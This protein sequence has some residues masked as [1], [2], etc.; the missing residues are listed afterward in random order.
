MRSTEFV[1]LCFTIPLIRQA[2]LLFIR[3]PG[4]TVVQCE[5]VAEVVESRTSSEVG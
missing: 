1:K 5:F 3:A 2:F 4:E